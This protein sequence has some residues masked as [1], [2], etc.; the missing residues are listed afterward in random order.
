MRRV[1][2]VLLDGRAVRSVASARRDV[3]GG[4]EIVTLEG[5]GLPGILSRAEGF[6][7]EHTF[8]CCMLDRLGAEGERGWT[9]MRLR[10]TPKCRGRILK[11]WCAGVDFTWEFSC[12]RPR[13]A[14]HNEK[15]VITHASQNDDIKT[16]VC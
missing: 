15:S 2:T 6:I 4:K 5:L 8:Q 14:D 1:A 16:R 9:K 7:C 11:V 10:P 12:R 13:A 3:V